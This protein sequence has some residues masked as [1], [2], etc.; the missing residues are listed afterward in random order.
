MMMITL[1]TSRLAEAVA[2]DDTLCD[3]SAKRILLHY[4]DERFSAGDE[5]VE[6]TC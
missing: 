6:G 3:Y 2:A 4:S 1:C 5:R